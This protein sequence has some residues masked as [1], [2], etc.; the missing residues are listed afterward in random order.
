MTP[1]TISCYNKPIVITAKRAVIIFFMSRVEVNIGKS[2]PQ[3]SARAAGI[4][5]SQAAELFELLGSKLYF[6]VDEQLSRRGG[7]DLGMDNGLLVNT[8]CRV[9]FGAR[10]AIPLAREFQA[11]GLLNGR[12]LAHLTLRYLSSRNENHFQIITD[13][14]VKYYALNL[15]LGKEPSLLEVAEYL[16]E[17]QPRINLVLGNCSKGHLPGEVAGLND[18][19]VCPYRIKPECFQLNG[20]Q[21]TPKPDTPFYSCSQS[22]CLVGYLHTQLNGGSEY[23]N[24]RFF[25]ILG[26]QQALRE[27]PNLLWANTQDHSQEFIVLGTCIFTLEWL[28]KVARTFPNFQGI[29]MLYENGCQTLGDRAIR[30]GGHRDKHITRLRGGGIEDNPMTRLLNVYRQVIRAGG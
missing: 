8:A 4:L 26:W 18:V 17:Q 6:M 1:S 29:V 12:D 2:I 28:I 7:Y 3:E 20:E 15:S 27:I 11:A 14:G 5:N 13:G 19:H 22:P 21:F 24:C 10:R 16:G 30:L 23:K 25:T 9:A